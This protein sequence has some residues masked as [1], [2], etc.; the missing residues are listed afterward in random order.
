MLPWIL[1]RAALDSLSAHR[2][3]SFLAML[4][5]IIGIASMITMLAMVRGAEVEVM[6]Q[7]ADLGAN[8]LFIRPGL[9]GA[10]GV[11]SGVHQN[12][13]LGDAEAVADEVPALALV[14]PVVRG[15]A[16]IKYFSR[17]VRSLLVGSSPEY[18]GVRSF[19]MLRGRAFTPAEVEGMAR[20]AVLG[21]IPA[22]SL[23]GESDPVG[24]T[25]KINGLNFRVVGVYGSKGEQGWTN[26]DDQV[27][28]P[29]TNAMKQFFGFDY[30]NEI[31]ARVFDETDI[32]RAVAGV[33]TVLRRCHRLKP[34]DP[35]D[36][37][38]RTM[39]EVRDMAA[40]I[41]TTFT[42][43]LGGIAGVSLII[44]GIGIMNIMLV[45]V[46]QRTREIGVRKAI[47]AKDRD[48]LRQFVI[49]ALVISAV[50]GLIGLLLGV[51]ASALIPRVTNF[52]TH[53][54]P[55]SVLLALLSSSAVGVFFG[56]YPAR[57]AARMDP[58]DALR[59]E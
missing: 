16:Q 7:I 29:C 14:A 56:Y 26:L 12:L 5:I 13:T 4:G 38:V 33:T 45:S 18:F 10:G 8:V 40:R 49:E 15:T 25:V 21:P 47:G 20:V 57:N 42:S 27:V 52:S 51:A 1:I 36:F 22:Q 53:V 34:D 46:T 50:G 6:Q 48:I 35:D 30:L 9:F 19:E 3:R 43:L 2:L 59:S 41:A 39:A 55:W 31:Q 58:I 32:R 17:N 37:Y 44:G 54:E 23:F 24:T 11:V 28:V